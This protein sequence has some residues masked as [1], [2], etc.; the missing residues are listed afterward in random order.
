MCMATLKYLEIPENIKKY[1]NLGNQ[2]LILIP[3]QLQINKQFNR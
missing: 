2:W 1:Y 3:I